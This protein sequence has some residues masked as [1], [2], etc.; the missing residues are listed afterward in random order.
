VAL[1]LGTHVGDVGQV[2]DVDL[3][4]ER[5]PAGKDRDQVLER[6]ALDRLAHRG[7]THLELTPDRVLVDR[8]A[9]R[10]AQRDQPVA[11][12]PVRAVREQSALTA[13]TL[14]DD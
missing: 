1:E 9:G 6:Q 4:R 11:Q 3:R 14:R 7:A 12:G 5:A 8:R 13:P 10:D 2:G